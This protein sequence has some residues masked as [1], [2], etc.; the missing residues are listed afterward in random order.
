MGGTEKRGGETKT[1]KKGGASW[2]KGGCLEKGWGA[3]DWNPL[4]NYGEGKPK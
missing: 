1:L 3:A 2:F 4:M